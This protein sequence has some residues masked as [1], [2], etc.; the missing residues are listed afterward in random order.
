ME[1]YGEI[2]VQ[3][4]VEDTRLW[5]CE[6]VSQKHNLDTIELIG[7]RAPKCIGGRSKVNTNRAGKGTKEERIYVT[8]D[9]EEH[10]IIADIKMAQ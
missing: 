9:P 5:S 6:Y 8:P 1:G 2:L 10:A 7:D 4:N 3:M